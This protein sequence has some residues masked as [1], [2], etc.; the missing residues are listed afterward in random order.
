MAFSY[1]E[2]LLK[3]LILPIVVLF[4]SIAVATILLI[5]LSKQLKKVNGYNRKPITRLI[6]VLPWALILSISMVCTVLCCSVLQYGINLVWDV[7]DNSVSIT[8]EIDEIEELS[9]SPLYTDGNGNRY[10]GALVTINNKQLLFMNANSLKKGDYVQVQYLSASCMV[11]SYSL[12]DPNELQPPQNI[13]DQRSSFNLN[14]NLLG[15]L[16]SVTL[17]SIGALLTLKLAK[18]QRHSL[19]NEVRQSIRTFKKHLLLS[20]IVSVIVFIISLLSSVSSF[21]YIATLFAVGSIIYNWLSFENTKIMY[22]EH[23]L[24]VSSFLGVSQCIPILQV[25]SVELALEK[26]YRSYCY[27]EVLIIR[28][29]TNGS[30]TRSIKFNSKQYEGVDRFL[31]FMASIKSN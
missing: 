17:I 8:G 12:S 26:K 20:I 23:Q 11:L 19:V 29:R 5:S 3:T 1:N 16:L 24:V 10:K 27:I 6:F 15:G 2:Y 18:K 28:F 31:Q 30:K 25:E 22:N 13:D 21:K 7:S 14:M 4:F 9:V